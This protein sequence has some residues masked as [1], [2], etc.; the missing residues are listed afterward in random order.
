MEVG[1]KKG[2]ERERTIDEGRL[3]SKLQRAD[4]EGPP[5]APRRG[6]RLHRRCHC[7]GMTERAQPARTRKFKTH[8]NKMQTKRTSVKAKAGEKPSIRPGKRSP[9]FIHNPRATTQEPPNV[10]DKKDVKP[11]M[12][13]APLPQSELKALRDVRAKILP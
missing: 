5:L 10:Q 1:G 4:L 9:C 12:R 13:P 6:G 8:E 2:G 11:S 3:T 7:H